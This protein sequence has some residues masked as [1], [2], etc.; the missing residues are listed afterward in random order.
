MWRRRRVRCRTRQ[1]LRERALSEHSWK[2][3]MHLRSWILR[4]R[5]FLPPAR[6]RYWSTQLPAIL[7]RIRLLLF[8]K[9]ESFDFERYFEKIQ[10]SEIFAQNSKL[11]RVAL[12]RNGENRGSDCAALE[13]PPSQN[14]RDSLPLASFP[15]AGTAM[16]DYP[17]DRTHF[18]SAEKT[19]WRWLES[20]KFQHDE[21]YN[22]E[23]QKFRTRSL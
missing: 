7:F 18:Q 8:F 11:F 19:L 16:P 3:Q 1:L 9:L 13:L 23:Q 20:R 17:A 5:R 10:V 12:R 2:F 6:N 22:A 21:F 14:R 4:R 15:G